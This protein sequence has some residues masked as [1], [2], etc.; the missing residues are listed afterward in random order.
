MNEYNDPFVR[1]NNLRKLKISLFDY[2]WLK[3][4]GN[5]VVAVYGKDHNELPLS[6]LYLSNLSKKIDED[7]FKFMDFEYKFNRT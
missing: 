2:V 4:K 3:Y 5:E 6:T 1:V 7:T